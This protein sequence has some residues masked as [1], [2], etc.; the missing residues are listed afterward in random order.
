[1][2]YKP[3]TKPAELATM[4]LLNTRMKLNSKD[5]LHYKSLKK[6]YEGEKQFD[7]LTEKLQCECLILNDLLL[8]LTNTTFQVDSLIIAQKK[9]CFYE[10]KNHEGDYYY[11]SDKLFK[12]PNLEIM[13]PLHQLGRSESLL[14]QLLLNHG[15]TLPID[16]SVVFINPTFT[17]YQAPL[18]QPIIYPTQVRRHLSD[19]NALP[20]K[21]T[22][23]H[24]ELADQLLSLHQSDSQ[25][26]KIPTYEYS[27]LRKG[28]I[29]PK[30]QSFSVAVEKR[31]SVCRGCGHAE[32]VTDAVL[33]NVKEFRILFP[34]EK[35]T[36]NIIYDWCQVVLSKQRIRSILL[37]N[38]TKVGTRRWSYFE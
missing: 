7:A 23:K 21:L 4:E 3:R 36:T 20:S 37:S 15:F 30:C 28:I 31:R 33:R 19:L 32:P 38:F 5:K 6:G 18:D 34:D 1:M 10:V 8:E 13:N 25:Y 35:I 9:I 27:Q 29:C 26:K 16:G 24:K 2:I 11:A 22:K 17:L 12:R 14:R